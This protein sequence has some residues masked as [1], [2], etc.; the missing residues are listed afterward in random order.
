MGFFDSKPV[1]TPDEFK[2]KVRAALSNHGW[3]KRKIDH[4]EGMI[5][6][7]MD[8]GSNSSTRGMDAKEVE[9]FMNYFETHRGTIEYSEHDRE[10]LHESLKKYL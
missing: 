2:H 3:P 1:V 9:D 10:A 4:V 8:A 5:H 6:G 7:Y